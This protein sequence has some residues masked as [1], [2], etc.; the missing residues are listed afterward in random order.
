M[1]RN[2][3]GFFFLFCLFFEGLRGGIPAGVGQKSGGESADG[4]GNFG[5]EE[6]AGN[7]G[8]REGVLAGATEFRGKGKWADGGKGDGAAERWTE[9]RK[10][11][12]SDRG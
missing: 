1:E 6:L 7:E 2:S 5:V 12:S 11:G 4:D 8:I 3:A 10:V 9:E